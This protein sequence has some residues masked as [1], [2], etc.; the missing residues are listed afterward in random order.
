M[1]DLVFREK[2]NRRPLTLQPL[3][4]SSLSALYSN[5]RDR[6]GRGGERRKRGEKVGDAEEKK[7]K[8][9]IKNG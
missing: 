3:P 8:R 7:G 2:V 6:M 5:P 4:L 9:R 1:F